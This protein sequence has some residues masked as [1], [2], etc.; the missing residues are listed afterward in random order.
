MTTLAILAL[1]LGV[2]I[3]AAV[4]AWLIWWHRRRYIGP[5]R[6]EFDNDQPLVRT[7]VFKGNE[8]MEI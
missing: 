2:L 3:A 7:K 8:E 4:P 1:A 6:H 5:E